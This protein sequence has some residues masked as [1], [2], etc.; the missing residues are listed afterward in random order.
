MNEE[1]IRGY[2]RYP[3]ICGDRIVFV[4]ENDLWEVSID[5]GIARRLTANKGEITQCAF[6]PDGKFI[7]F[8]GREEGHPEVYIMPSI[9]GRAERL[10]YLGAET[11]VVGWDPDYRIVFASNRKEPF[12][13]I[14]SLYV[15]D[16]DG[17]EYSKLPFGNA[18][19]ISFGDKGVVLGR[20]TGDPARWKRYKGGTAGE[21]WI[22]E[23]NSGEFHPLI[24]LKGN[25]ACPMWIG[26]R[27]YFLSD[28]EKIGN[29]YS[30]LPTGKDL[31]RETKH[32]DFYARNAYT[33]G[34]RIVYH[35][36]TDI[37]LFDT[38]SNKSRKIDIE[39]KSPCIQRNRKFVECD[40]YLED[41]ELNED[42]SKITVTARGGAF[43]L[44]NW[45]SSVQQY[46]KG[47]GVRY[48]LSR[49]LDKDRLV[50]ISDEGGEEYIEIYNI[51]ANKL[52]N[53]INGLDIGRPYELKKIP[54][55]NG[56]VL[57]NHRHELIYVDISEKK[58]R[59]LDRSRYGPIEGFDPSPDGKWI[60]YSTTINRSLKGI[61][62]V[63]VES[64]VIKQIT[65][66]VRWDV[67]PCFDP[68]G[69]FLYFLSHRVFDP[70]YDNMHFELSFPGGMRP[71]LIT[72][73]KKTSSPFIPEPKGF[74]KDDKEEKVKKKK[75]GLAELNI[76]FDGIEDRI[77]PFPVEVGIYHNIAVSDNKVFYTKSPIGTKKGFMEEKIPPADK[78]LRIFDL[79]KQ[80]EKVFAKEITDFKLSSNGGALIMR[81]GNRLRVVDA[82]RNLD[83]EL[84]KD[85]KPSR[86]SGWI[87][88][89]RVK[90]SIDPE[91]EWRQMFREAW[92]LQRDYFWREDFEGID[93]KEVFNRYY[94]LVSRI[95]TRSEFSDLIWELQGELGSSHAYEMGGDYN[96]P[97]Q[98]QIG[99]LGAD[100]EYD[101]EK[102]AYRI[103]KILKGDPWDKD[104][105]PPLLAPGLNINEGMLLVDVNGYRVGEYDLPDRLLVNKVN[106][107]IQITIA[108]R[109]GKGERIVTIKTLRDERPL[110]YREWVNGNRDYVHS[111]SRGKVGY[112]HIP[113]MGT[114]GYAEFHR[115]FLAELDYEGLIVDVRYNGGGHVSSLILEKLARER[116]GYDETR[117]MG[118]EP[119]PVESVR[120][121]LAAVT[122]EH[123]GSD[124][125]IFSHVFKLMNLGK[126]IGKRT[127]GG[128]VGIW[129]RNWLVDGTITTQPE[130]SF[131]FKDVGFEVENYGTDP[132]IEVDIK[133]QD[134]K[135]GKD[136]QLDKAIEVILDE[137]AKNPPFSI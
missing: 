28:H 104:N 136:P 48:R 65:N 120:G 41:Y 112:L 43:S 62:I 107:E 98:Y 16:K 134:Y 132:D 2:Y 125:D 44:A 24:E 70:V 97:P 129:P 31:R 127:W 6:S 71:Y 25:L 124:G 5:G 80:Q 10:T 58:I 36:G 118:K 86:E 47:S 64:G 99:F 18:R 20:N 103:K 53:K 74:G 100:F 56:I 8:T 19:D 83:E 85:T 60:A 116:V 63:E 117:W 137:I 122:N 45:E 135:L 49:F 119:Y 37:F 111:K 30:C 88:L 50:M 17:G 68:K 75:E 15:I 51:K 92:R 126:L 102:N 55:R 78:V 9:G 4:S 90:I 61:K 109:D 59:I 91:S 121:P 7:S 73:N 57:S 38:V 52:E 27:I 87:D 11:Y 1:N 123:A 22:D 69:R 106:E 94:P 96:P 35:K 130:F 113:D 26:K 108:R 46:G 89:N 114:K 23:T 3:I 33:D 95:T 66:P 105:P 21:L 29:I 110:R 131:W 101:K 32:K 76:D 82:N 79:K 13:R 14:Y 128:V 115:Y 40:K 34:K 93:W 81:V 12:R 72:L 54:N 133:P 39:Y 67:N 42:G 77:L 84:P